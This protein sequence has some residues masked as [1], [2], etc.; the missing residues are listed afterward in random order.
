[1]STYSDIRYESAGGAVTVYANLDAFPSS[2]NSV[3]DYA[4]ATNTKAL[5][6]WDGTEWDRV[7]TGNNET[8]RLTTTPASILELNADG[9][10]SALTI[11]AE[12]PE[13]E[14]LAARCPA[15]HAPQQLN[16]SAVHGAA[17]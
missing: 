5:Y 3:G 8:P 9:S 17:S 14:R 7:S 6:I 1:M 4:W 16:V 15:Q 11:A 12:D 10:T 13:G 2:G